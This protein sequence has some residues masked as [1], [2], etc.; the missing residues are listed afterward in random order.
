MS[1]D[2]D[3]SWDSTPPGLP[4]QLL[5]EWTQAGITEEQI[6]A[7]A[8]HLPPLIAPGSAR[9]GQ[10]RETLS[11][12]ERRPQ[13]PQARW[14]WR[15]AAVLLMLVVIGAALVG[16][17]ASHRHNGP[18]TGAPVSAPGWLQLHPTG[19]P[20]APRGVASNGAVGYDVAHNRLLFFGGVT[21]ND[22]SLNDTWVLVNA[23]GTT[24]APAWVQLATANTPAPH[25]G[26]A[27]AY[28]AASNRLIV[29][30]GCLGKCTPL[31]DSVYVLA[32]ANGL[33]GTPT[34]EQLHPTG[35]Q[36]P[37]RT[38][39][40]A[41]YDASN[42]RLIIFGGEDGIHTRYND[43]WVLTHAN[44][45]GGTPAWTPLAPSGDLPPARRSHVAVYLPATN[46]M[47]VFGGDSRAS[48]WLNDLWV[49]I[50]A[51]GLGGASVW[52]QLTPGSSVPAARV[53]PALIYNQASNHLILYGGNHP[54]G[55]LG[56]CW[57]LTDANGLGGVPEWEELAPFGDAPVPRNSPLAVYNP[58]SQHLILFGGSTSSGMTLNDLWVLALTS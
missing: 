10:E 7:A 9:V 32:N 56:D 27:G 17:I 52:S 16:L 38:N 55:A 4:P 40:T 50:N 46:Q 39:F 49:L 23:D 25:K 41:V 47:V 45:L 53:T 11:R 30:G 15:S 6:R 51:N 3:D 26:Q 31:D 44:G 13:P 48:A 12:Q 5:Q 18:P 8:K 29:Y 33:G 19:G 36:P 28:D 43:A 14:L 58:I 1:K 2:Q 35:G 37:S 57:I 22:T 54:G 34:W 24:G 42:N 21:T 20:P